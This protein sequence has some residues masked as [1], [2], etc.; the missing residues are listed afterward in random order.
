M[1]SV[2]VPS[3]NEEANIATCL[4]SLSHQTVPRDQY[5][6]IVVDGDSRDRTREIAEQYADLVFIQT[7]RKEILSRPRMRTASF[8][9]PGSRGSATTSIAILM[10]SRSTARYTHANPG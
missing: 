3:F 7:S 8:L 6:I 10:S 5:E 1:I 9:P 4:D 2:I